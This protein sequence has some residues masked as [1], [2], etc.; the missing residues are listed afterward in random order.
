MVIR[1]AETIT[2]HFAD[3]YSALW[4][5]RLGDRAVVRA[6]VH[7][8]YF[9]KTF[10]KQVVNLTTASELQSRVVTSGMTQP[11]AKDICRQVA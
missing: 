5:C 7:A 4:L 9:M 11:A 3:P 8:E 1:R 6:R 10:I 2:S